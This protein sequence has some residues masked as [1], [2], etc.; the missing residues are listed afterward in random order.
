MSLPFTVEQ[1]LGVFARYNEAVWPGQL[2]LH[3]LAVT[4]VAALALRTPL[5]SRLISAS[6]AFFWAWAG[7]VYHGLFFAPV[8]P[9][10]L[11]FGALFVAAAGVFAWQGVVRDRLRFLL[12]GSA[13]AAVGFA[14]V[15]YA[16]LAYPLLAIAFGHGYP[17]MP[18]FGAP[19]PVTLFTLGMLAFLQQPYPR[20]VFF[21]PLAWVLVASQAT[22]LLRMYEDLG[23]LFAGAAGLWLALRPFTPRSAHP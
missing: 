6:L 8:N 18:T 7:V 9:A 5:A 16:L 10:A 2:S 3:L 14:L 13:E 19:C 23:L 12:T 11:L 21:V 15:A 17:A 1:F 20:H 4:C 22:V